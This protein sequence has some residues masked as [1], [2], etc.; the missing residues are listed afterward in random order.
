MSKKA[1]IELAWRAV[2]HDGAIWTVILDRIVAAAYDLGR[3]AQAEK[4]AGD[5]PW[6]TEYD[7]TRLLAKRLRAKVRRMGGETK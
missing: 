2:G 4:D 1:D 5:M 7:R 6:P 3:A